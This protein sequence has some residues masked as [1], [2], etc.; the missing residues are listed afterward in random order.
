M[1]EPMGVIEKLVAVSDVPLV[2]DLDGTLVKTDLLVESVLSSVLQRPRTLLSL[3]GWIASGKTV[4]KRELAQHGHLDIDTL[5]YNEELVEHC[6]DEHNRGRRIVLATAANK[7]L[8]DAVAQ[9]FGFFDTVFASDD[10]TNLAGVEKAKRLCAEFGESGF[11]YAGDTEIDLPVWQKANRIIGVNCATGLARRLRETYPDARFIGR[12]A[13]RL[14]ILARAMRVHQWSKNVLLLVPAVAAHAVGIE[15]IVQ[16]LLGIVAFCLVASA[17]YLVNDLVDLNGDRAHPTKKLRPFASGDL[18]VIN[19]IW[20]VPALLATGFGIATFLSWQFMGVLASYLA[21]TFAYSLWLKRKLLVD[22]LVLGGLY[23]LRI[24]AGAA[25]IGVA[26]SPWLLGFSLFLFLALAIIKRYTEL[27]RMIFLQRAAPSSRGYQLE[28]LP[29]LG[30]LG[31]ASSFCSV[32]ILSLYINSPAVIPLYKTPEL[33]WLACPMLVYWLS[34]L[35]M[36]AHRGHMHDDPIVFALKD[37]VSLLTITASTAVV[38][39]AALV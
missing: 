25:A 39:A 11:D 35:L 22:M 20:L 38:A 24:V 2:V 16:S 36:I 29:I 9:K 12:R 28:D 8:A 13:G 34:R 26:V 27:Q 23:T 1:G 5:P 30:A 3:P 18:A 17:I 32:V 15:A 33:L 10:R 4:L 6:Q 31:A 37:K 7:V 21:L 19:A 14:R